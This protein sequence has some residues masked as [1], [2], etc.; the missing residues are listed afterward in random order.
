MVRR[1]DKENW[2]EKIREL[3]GRKI[4]AQLFVYSK[5]THGLNH[6]VNVRDWERR[7]V[8]W[9]ESMGF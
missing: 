6:N 2:D 9:I 7:I 8:D 5:A 4:P 1:H 3:H